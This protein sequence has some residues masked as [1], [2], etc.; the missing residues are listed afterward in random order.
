MNYLLA[1]FFLLLSISLFFKKFILG[2]SNFIFLNYSI[3][4]I[5]IGFILF[6]ILIIY[7]STDQ[8]DWN[9]VMWRFTTM[10]LGILLILRGAVMS[11]LGNKL[12]KLLE[13]F[14]KHYYKL[15]VPISLFLF[16][17]SALVISRDYLGEIPNIE[18]CI[19]TGEIEIICGVSNPEDMVYFKKERLILMSEFGG[20][21]PYSPNNL[22]GSF[23]FY[24]TRTNEFINA[25]IKYGTN[26][27][28]SENCFRDKNSLF[29]PHGIDLIKR[30]DNIYQLGVVNHVPNESIE[31]FEVDLSNLEPKL[32]WRGCIDAPETAYFNDISFKNQ[33]EF[34]VTHMYSR[35]ISIPEWML[36]SLLKSNTGYVYYWNSK[37]F[38]K[39]NK[40]SGGQ[41]N[42]VLYDKDKDILYVAYNQSDEIRRFNLSK[43]KV[44]SNF[45]HSPD[46]ITLKDG[47]LLLTALDFQPLDGLS[48]LETNKNCSLPFSII[49]MDADSLEILK[50][51]SYKKTSFGLPTVAL[52][53]EN[54]IFVGSFHSD[55]IALIQER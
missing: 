20:I 54:K 24:N 37:D 9:E 13:V 30:N 8:A 55:R 5:G 19:S 44:D 42:G 51:Y 21:K 25:D 50:K 32:I 46:N 6:G 38:Q 36:A 43:G 35:S 12:Y 14:E 23:K 29:G 28:G 18:E 17:I 1:S 10:I 47:Q 7:I 3:K 31:F 16:S 39:V 2:F 22:S 45:I 41:P 34:F 33:N 11:L 52:L 26:D 40:S 53:I 4:K 48:C 15:S 27:W 49:K